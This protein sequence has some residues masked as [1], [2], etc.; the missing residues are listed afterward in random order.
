M[1]RPNSF[2]A[3]PALITLAFLGGCAGRAPEYL[4]PPPAGTHAG[5]ELPPGTVLHIGPKG[6]A[7]SE[8]ILPAERLLRIPMSIRT[9]LDGGQTLG[10]IF[11]GRRFT[12]KQ[13]ELTAAGDE[14]AEEIRNFAAIPSY[15]GGGFLF[16]SALTFHQTLG[17]TMVYRANTWEGPLS[18]FVE[19]PSPILRI[20]FGRQGAILQDIRGIRKE[21]ELPSG[22][23]RPLELPGL[24]HVSALPGKGAVALAEFGRIFVLSQ[25]DEDFRERTGVNFITA[26]RETAVSNGDLWIVERS[27]RALRLNTEGQ[28]VEDQMPN[29]EPPAALAPKDARW[30]HETPPRTLAL[31]MGV[32][33]DEST[34]LVAAFGAV[35]RV[36][37]QTG[38]ILDAI[39][40][41]EIEKLECELAPVQNDVIGVCKHPIE[42]P[43]LIASGFLSKTGPKIERYFDSGTAV[44]GND[45]GELIAAAPCEGQKPKPWEACRRGTDGS[46][47]T[48]S[49]EAAAKTVISALGPNAEIRKI[50]WLPVSGEDPKAIVFG[51][52]A[53]AVVASTPAGKS[54]PPKD[55]IVMEI[56]K[57]ELSTVILTSAFERNRTPFQFIDRRFA[58]RKD[59]SIEGW[60][61]SHG[62]FTSAKISP[63]GTVTARP[64][65]GAPRHLFST[66]GSKAVGVHPNGSLFISL[67]YGATWQS[68]SGP[69]V[70]TADAFNLFG[71]G[72]CSSAGCD[73]GIWLRLGWNSKREP[74]SPFTRAP[75]PPSLPPPTNLPVIACVPA[76]SAEQSSPP[77]SES[78]V[79]SL[80]A[81][82]FQRPSPAGF[83]SGAFFSRLLPNPIVR[84]QAGDAGGAPR[85]VIN[86][87]AAPSENQKPPAAHIGYRIAFDS[88]GSIRAAQL[89]FEQFGLQGLHVQ[90]ITPALPAN[91]KDSISY[92]F[93]TVGDLRAFGTLSPASGTKLLSTSG[94]IDPLLL[95][96]AILPSKEFAVLTVS[97]SGDEHAF[98]ISS[99][100]KQISPLSGAPSGTRETAPANPDALAIAPNGDVFL[101]R[102]PSGDEPASQGNPALLLRLGGGGA[103]PIE[104]L[105]PWST[106]RNADDPACTGDPSGVRAV[107]QTEGPWVR[108]EG[109]ALPENRQAPQMTAIVRWNPR[110]VCLEAIELADT[111]VRF[112]GHGEADSVIVARYLPKAEAMQ[113]AANVGSVRTQPLSCSP[114][115]PARR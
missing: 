115:M 98:R 12:Y 28:F 44:Y 107:I 59:G 40:F 114:V 34:A 82:R 36:S 1:R 94:V 90:N 83:E 109:R 70:L 7:P 22:R 39:R 52:H 56:N 29:P 104:G 89:P 15:L 110:R 72:Q 26:P 13:G 85:V 84:N 10:L 3:A 74:P 33:V 65:F 86:Y 108:V 103:S 41:A 87:P 54:G 75:R 19:L 60:L 55:P 37:L 17:R 91:P 97:A 69:P 95:S 78:T 67:D 27:G 58:A 102:L 25:G 46:F 51:T 8:F 112:D 76:G 64:G 113:V 73:L 35:A 99:N 9:P 42:G 50:R 49:A 62:V 96:A 57:R 53:G 63:S 6:Q 92:F 93:V 20:A 101:L 4:P 77:F 66:H 111:P 100:G 31:R 68:I 71:Q 21:F 81:L 61:D 106:L 30:K 5:V 105:A 88:D 24:V 47:K 48:F 43:V 23:P 11:G 16:W 32:A 38:E 45:E 80:G 14:G 2:F 18:P 79:V